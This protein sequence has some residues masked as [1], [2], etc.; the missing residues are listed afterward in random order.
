MWKDVRLNSIEQNNQ[1]HVLSVDHTKSMLKTVRH[2]QVL[3][4]IV[5]YCIFTRPVASCHNCTPVLLFVSNWQ[6]TTIEKMDFA[7]SGKSSLVGTAVS[8]VVSRVVMTYEKRWTYERAL[9]NIMMCPSA[10]PRRRRVP[11]FFLLELLPIFWHDMVLHHLKGILTLASDVRME[12]SR[13]TFLLI[14]RDSPISSLRCGV[15]DRAVS[16]LASSLRNPS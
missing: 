14:E 11:G 12:I 8:C 16:V 3:C 5:Q 4:R 15:T 13:H 6:Q 2:I 9:F 7:S 10:M 1:T